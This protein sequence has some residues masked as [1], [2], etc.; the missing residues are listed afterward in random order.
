MAYIDILEGDAEGHVRFHSPEDVK[1]VSEARAA[2]QREHS[3]KL[4][5]LSGTCLY[6]PQ[7]NAKLFSNELLMS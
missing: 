7:L 2:L 1:A 3:W 4:E 5:I 6:L